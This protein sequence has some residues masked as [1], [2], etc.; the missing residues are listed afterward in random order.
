MS[1]VEMKL[2]H[3]EQGPRRSW[4]GL[5][6]R[7]Q[8]SV[9]NANTSRSPGHAAAT[10]TPSVAL[11]GVIFLFPVTLTSLARVTPEPLLMVCSLLFMLPFFELACARLG[12]GEVDPVDTGQWAIVAGIAFAAGVTAKI[13]FIP[14]VVMAFLFPTWRARLRFAAAAA[15]AAFVFILP[16]IGRLSVFGEWLKALVTHRGMYGGGESGAPTAAD[17]LEG[18]RKMLVM[19]AFLPV[20]IVSLLVFAILVPK[21]RKP[22]LLTIL[23][24]LVQFAIVVADQQVPIRRWSHAA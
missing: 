13:T 3:T 23:C 11:Q 1:V 10:N 17:L 6:N 7:N 9:G 19:E 20:W 2:Q 22:L 18:A 14:L 4:A 5:F 15:V 8:H 21:M 16:I 24:C 12:K